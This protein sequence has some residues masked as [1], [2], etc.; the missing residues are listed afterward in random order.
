MGSD[1]FFSR[2]G[3]LFKPKQVQDMQQQPRNFG[4]GQYNHLFTY[5]GEKNLGEIGPIKNYRLDYVALRLRSWQ[6]YHE[7]EITQTLLNRFNTWLIGNGLKLQSEPSRIVLES[8]GIKLDLAGFSKVVEARF[9]LWAESKMSDHASMNSANRHAGTAFKNALLGGD[10]LVVMRYKKGNVTVE[11]IDGEH[12]Q[13]PMFGTE[14]YPEKLANGNMIK[15]GIE[16]DATGKH[17][18][19]YVRQADYSIKPIDA[20]GKNTNLQMAFMVYGLKYRIDNVRGVPLF[21]VILE[22]L[23][24]LERYKE[25]TVGSAEERQK[26]IMQ[27]VHQ[28]GA[29]GENPQN[30]SLAKAFDWDTNLNDDLPSDIN[31]REMANLIS[32]STNKQTYNMPPGS[33]LKGLESKNELYF[34][35]FYTKNFDIVC[36]AVGVPPNV[37]MSKYDENFS[38]SRAALKDWENTLNVGRTDFSFQYYKQV[39]NFWLEM[40]ILNNRVQAPGYLGAAVQG[41]Q[42]L[43]EGYR[44]ARFIGTP[45]PHIDP[46]KEVAAERLKLGTTG[47]S[48]PLTTAEAATEALGGG[49]YSHNVEQYSQE[50]Q[51]SKDLGVEVIVPE[52]TEGDKGDGEEKEKKKT[53]GKAKAKD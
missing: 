36:A 20:I 53:K 11:L 27:I 7:S 4:Y 21:A 29:S 39:Y 45:V 42:M 15:S 24:K 3:N 49:E 22:T 47:A 5:N 19:Y 25:A 1:S 16:V 41:N 43:L 44:K 28:L 34:D 9:N 50:L 37:A 48:I 30:K 33:E 17:V 12:V 32:V 46:V 14:W 8:E 18:R 10:V 35:A 40:E 38:A 52:S 26:I 6:S 51:T 31:G 23:K 13:S 2:V